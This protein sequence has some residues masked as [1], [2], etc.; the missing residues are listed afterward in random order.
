MALSFVK[1][2]TVRLELGDGEWVDIRK[3]LNKGELDK[4]RTGHLKN[5]RPMDDGNE[6]TVDF[7]TFATRRAMAY[8]V[9]WSATKATAT[10]GQ[11]EPVPFTLDTLRALDEVSFNAIDAALTRYVEAQEAEKK[12]PTVPS[13]ATGNGGNERAQTLA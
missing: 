5:L 1:P 2:S 9:N 8:I 10:E 4:M 12:T 7:G 13:G 6:I 11:R 3:E